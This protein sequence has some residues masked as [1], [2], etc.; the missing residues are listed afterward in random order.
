MQRFKG[1]DLEIKF[2]NAGKEVIE[3]IGLQLDDFEEEALLAAPLGDIIR[4]DDRAPLARSIDPAIFR[5]VFPEIFSAFEVAGSFE[6]YLTVFRRI[7]GDE[8]Q[9]LFTVPNPG[10][11][12]ID[13]IADEVILNDLISRK[14]VDNAFV[15][16]EVVDEDGD[17][18]S[19]QTIKGF[20]TQFELELT[21]FELVPNGIFTEITLT[22]I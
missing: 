1:D 9:V 3:D 6:S 14:I 17:N 5:D 12:E 19:V 18:I 8:V 2:D 16:E 15:F 22:Q 4:E 13:I 7:F 20:Q 21:L 10:H 11:L